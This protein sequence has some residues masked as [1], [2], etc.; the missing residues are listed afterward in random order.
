MGGISMFDD[1][2]VIRGGGDIAT[3]IAHRLHRSGFRI[4]MLEIENPTMI[5]RKVSFGEA[6]FEGQ[7]VVEDVKAVRTYRLED[8]YEIWNQGHIPIMVDK[9]CSIINKLSIDILVDGTLIKKNM[10]NNKEMAA[11]TVGVGPGFNAGEDVDVVIETDRGHDL[12]KLIF[13]GYA[14][15]DTGVP[16]KILGYDVERVIRAPCE[17][18]IENLLEIGDMVKK[19]EIIAYVNGISVISKIDGV[20]RGI[21][22]NKSRVKKD[23]KIADV[24]PRGIKEYCFT[25]SDKARAIGGGVLEAIL[26]MKR[27]KEV[28]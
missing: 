7:I 15:P 10:G 21:I 5:R 27:I 6:I 8:I 23:F 22:K 13:R 9:E 17:G 25:I 1:I 16:G 19:D 26:Y 28:R 12:G 11:I 3:G 18:I 24:D 4:L 2:V 14:K 20:L